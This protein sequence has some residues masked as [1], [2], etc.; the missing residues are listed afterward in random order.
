[1]DRDTTAQ[2]PEGV[3]RQGVAGQSHSQTV[4]C[5]QQVHAANKQKA[6]YCLYRHS[7]IIKH[8]DILYY[9]A[10]AKGEMFT[11]R[12]NQRYY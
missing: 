2:A 5:G 6:F 7:V 3:A 12:P 10:I 1:M 8:F 11:I 4:H 9:T